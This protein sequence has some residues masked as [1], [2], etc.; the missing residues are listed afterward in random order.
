VSLLQSIRDGDLLRRQSRPKRHG[1]W[2]V[3]LAV[4]YAFCEN[5]YFGWHLIPVTGIEVACD[6]IALLLLIVTSNAYAQGEAK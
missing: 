4:I 5:A 1:G 6:G 3:L 2:N